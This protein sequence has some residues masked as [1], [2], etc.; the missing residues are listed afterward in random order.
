ME[1]KPE[2]KVVAWKDLHGI[3]TLFMVVDKDGHDCGL[4]PSE[5]EAI[6]AT[7]EMAKAATE[8]S[9]EAAQ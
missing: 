4:Y 5:H 3:E 8:E 9:E 2:F 1:T 7:E 6:A